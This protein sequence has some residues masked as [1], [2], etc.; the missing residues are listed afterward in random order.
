MHLA[1]RPSLEIL[2]GLLDFFLLVH[3]ERTIAHNRFLDR[4]TAEQQQFGIAIGLQA[5]LGAF[6]GK[7]RHLRLAQQAAAIDLDRTAEHHHGAG[8]PGPGL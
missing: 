8:K 5:H 2:D 3:H 7:Q 4:L 6:L 1:K